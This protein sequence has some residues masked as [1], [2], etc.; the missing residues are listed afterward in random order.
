M[1][2][3]EAEVAVLRRSQDA[4]CV[5]VKKS[6]LRGPLMPGSRRSSVGV[7]Q[8]AQLRNPSQGSKVAMVVLEP[9]RALDS[10][11]RS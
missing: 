10:S 2:R 3:A 4:Q 1:C 7:C 6:G 5:R 9:R 11:Q 8:T